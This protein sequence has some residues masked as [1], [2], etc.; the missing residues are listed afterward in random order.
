MWNALVRDITAR[1]EGSGKMVGALL[2]VLFVGAC[3]NSG[4]KPDILITLWEPECYSES[5]LSRRD[6][7]DRKHDR[8]FTNGGTN[9]GSTNGGGTNGGGT[10][11]GPTGGDGPDNNGFGNGDQDAPGRSASHNN[12]END[13]GGRSDPSHG[14]NAGG[15]G[16]K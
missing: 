14:G 1:L 16:K 15:Q 9:G 13:P 4:L 7:D 2:L 6:C 11:G 5:V 3:V 10:N 8:D 12:A